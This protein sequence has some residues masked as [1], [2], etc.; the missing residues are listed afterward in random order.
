MDTPVSTRRLAGLVPPSADLVFA[1]CGLAVWFAINCVGVEIA[2]SNRSL[3]TIAEFS[4]LHY[5]WPLTPFLLALAGLL[6]AHLR[7]DSSGP[8]QNSSRLRQLGWLASVL[9]SVR[10][11]A[12]WNPVCQ[13]FPYLTLLWSPHATWAL[14]LCFLVYPHLAIAWLS[15]VRLRIRHLAVAIF[16]VCSVSYGLY[17]LYFCQVTMIHGDEGQY[18]R[19]TQSLI[20]DGDMD[21]ANNLESSTTG[22]FHVTEF[23]LAKAPGSPP[24]K[25]HS[26][27]PIGLSVLLVPAYWLGL[28]LWAN[29]RLSC[30]LFMC[31]LAAATAASAFVWLCRLGVSV[32][33]ALLAVSVLA[34]TAPF[35][36]YSNQ[37]YPEIPALL[38][39]LITLAC[40]AHWLGSGG[41]YR[42]MGRWETGRLG[43]LALLAWLLPF[44]HPRYLPLAALLLAFLLLQCWFSVANKRNLLFLF[45]VG[46]AMT[47]AHIRFNYTFSGDW[48]GPFR[49][50]SA[51]SEGAL[52][53]VVWLT[54]L[55]GHWLLGSHGLLNASPVFLFSLVGLALVALTRNRLALV[56]VALYTCTATVNGAH[57]DWT[58]GFGY[59]GRFLITALPA[60]VLGISWCLESKK[61][62]ALGLFLMA[63]AWTVSLDT[64]ITTVAF[65]EGGYNGTNHE[66]RSV[67]QY[68]PWQAHFTPDRDSVAVA[69]IVLVGI[70]V[71]TGTKALGRYR[72]ALVL[73]SL[74]VPKLWSLTIPAERIAD[75]AVGLTYD[76]SLQVNRIKHGSR[77]FEL[78]LKS[79]MVGTRE[80]DGTFLAREGVDEL[81]LLV[82]LDGPLLDPGYYS[83]DTPDLSSKSAIPRIT[84]HLVSLLYT[85]VPA[86]SLSRIHMSKPLVSSPH[87]GFAQP[88]HVGQISLGRFYVEYSGF[89][90][91]RLG[92]F[93]LRQLAMADKG[94]PELVKVF[95]HD[96]AT[97]G[98]RI[99]AG[100]FY[101][102]LEPGFYRVVFEF[103]G[104]LLP[105]I[106]ERSPRPIAMAVYT[107][108][109]SV[110]S[111]YR[112]R[113][114]VD[115]W[116]SQDRLEFSGIDDP[117][118][119]RPLVERFQSPWWISVPHNEGALDINFS[120]PEP[121]DTWFLVRYDGAEHL[122]VRTTTLFRRKVHLTPQ[123]A[124]TGKGNTI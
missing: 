71:I 15:S 111:K 92:Q 86:V 123:P 118:Y 28:E 42:S 95:K 89:G 69:G 115:L 39:T 79:H 117:D 10:L 85:N 107:F 30:A 40:M 80:D 87:G 33:A 60:L 64:V 57:P 44:L 78:E 94:N 19:V 54:S 96:E 8:S 27:H 122:D 76:D 20:R 97:S 46:S 45:A 49:P 13:V 23:G 17:T 21:L 73:L 9:S 100:V 110:P 65:P 16:L 56:C 121:R 68:Y 104:P 109:P 52:N 55:P 22:E 113:Q 1:A 101:P 72:P 25:V 99:A 11:L 90:E 62:T 35:F 3:S 93:T 50:G 124:E 32:A 67:N 18:L 59:P 43:L 120:L 48:L 108:D 102:R 53:P 81:G 91:I 66:Y 103:D 34:S 7:P 31:L 98:D 106:F 5:K 29:P 105:G 24:G 61:Q 116:F 37:L 83:F 58:F 26:V 84:G 77:T 74:I 12:L 114:L 6:L 14:C 36:L 82:N 112:G 70:L 47:V 119:V 41:C 88:F 75:A 51:W 38:I 4:E 2:A 63:M